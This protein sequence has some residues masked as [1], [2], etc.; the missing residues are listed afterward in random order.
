MSLQKGLDVR[1]GAVDHR[2]ALLQGILQRHAAVHGLYC[3]AG[4]H[5]LCW[6]LC[7][8]AAAAAALEGLLRVWALGT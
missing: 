3:G 2:Q 5:V 4:Q 7:R 8:P 6:R 1:W